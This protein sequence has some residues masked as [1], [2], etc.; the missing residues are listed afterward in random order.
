MGLSDTRR[1]LSEATPYLASLLKDER[2]ACLH[3]KCQDQ[4][5]YVNTRGAHASHRIYRLLA[6]RIGLGRVSRLD[7]ESS[8]REQA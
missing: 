6:N 7:E 3:I 1:V 4:D 8:E 5:M 2:C